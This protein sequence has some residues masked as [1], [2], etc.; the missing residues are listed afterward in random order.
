MNPIYG[1][2]TY[3][4]R[5]RGQRWGNLTVLPLAAKLPLTAS[6]GTLW[7]WVTEVTVVIGLI[8]SRGALARPPLA[9]LRDVAG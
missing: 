8:G 3:R 5:G 1:K 4:A 9:V 7:L 6:I 2:G